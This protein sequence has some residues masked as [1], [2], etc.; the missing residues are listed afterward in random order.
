MPRVP[1]WVFPFP[2]Y[3]CSVSLKPLYDPEMKKI[4]C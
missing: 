3:P 4:K 1:D 2:L